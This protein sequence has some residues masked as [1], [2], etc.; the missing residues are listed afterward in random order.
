VRNFDI[1]ARDQDGEL[2]AGDAI[3]LDT[4]DFL[5]KSWPRR[6][7]LRSQ[8]F[9]LPNLLSIICYLLSPQGGVTYPR[10]NTSSPKRSNFGSMSETANSL[11][12]TPDPARLGLSPAVNMG[13]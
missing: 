7:L 6:T 3:Y 12:V 9:G 11:A 5:R 10:T 1:F 13:A 4:F 8:A 2:L